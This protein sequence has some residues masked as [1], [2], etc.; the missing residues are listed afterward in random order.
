M[1]GLLRRAIC[2]EGLNLSRFIS[3]A[4]ESG[5]ALHALKHDGPRR[6]RAIAC[7]DD[8]PALQSL[9]EGG[10]WALKTGRRVGVA[11]TLDAIKAR[12]L[13][14]ALSAAG[15]VLLMLSSRVIWRI[16]VADG[17]AYAA[18][19]RSALAEMNV[20][21]PLLRR[22]ID[23][24]QLRDALEWRYPRVAWVECGF[25]G[26]TL[27]VRPVEGVLPVRE[28]GSGPCDLLA[29]Q[30]GVIHHIITR[31]GT[32]VVEVGDVVRAGDLLIR[33]EER[34]AEGGVRPVAAR[35]SVTARI[36][37]HASV[38]MSAS[39]VITRYTGR[40][41][42]AW[43]VRSPWFD[44]WQ[45]PEPPYDACDTAVEE[46]PLGGFFLPLTLYVETYHEAEFIHQSRDMETV[47]AECQAA[48][49]RKL[50]EKAPVTESFIDIW[51]NC[52][53]IDT[54]NVSADAFGEMLVEIAVRAP[55][56]AAP[57]EQR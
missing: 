21:P 31:A 52:S 32:P 27:V 50:H 49:V 10:G 55:A 5:I 15:L 46:I 43:T 11:R 41:H 44:L 37:L 14:W 36:W 48:A 20:K 57:D 33:G 45:M 23:L 51:G 25:R 2:V 8:L 22:S 17:G 47:K 4:G 12:W 26:V 34:T 42:T 9:A 53:M 19:I 38:R 30:D 6:L 56:M 39:E 40:T 13:L 7:E 3:R 35:G 54:E 18:E 24:G 28:E 16:E 29:E 1:K